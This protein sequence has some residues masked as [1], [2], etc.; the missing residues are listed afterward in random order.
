MCQSCSSCSNSYNYSACPFY[1]AVANLFSCGCNSS[2]SGCGAYSNSCG[3]SNGY[4]CN[5]SS[6]CASQWADYGN[7]CNRCGSYDDY[8]ARQYALYPYG[9]SSSCGIIF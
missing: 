2:H 3:Y 1:S 6:Y 8:Y 4:G 5:R 7:G 9:G